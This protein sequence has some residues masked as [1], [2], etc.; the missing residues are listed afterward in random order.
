MRRAI[1]RTPRLA[2]DIS[3]IFQT[4]GPAAGFIYLRQVVKRSREIL[5]VGMLRPADEAMSGRTWRFYVLGTTIELDGRLFSGAREMYC[6]KVYFARQGFEVH[7]NDTVVDLG[8]NY[9]LFSV[10]AARCGARVIAV[11]AQ[12]GCAPEIE[13]LA[14]LNG[15]Q[16]RIQVESVMVGSGGLYGD[17]DEFL[18]SGHSQ[19]RLPQCVRFEDLLR[20]HKIER[21]DFLKIDIEG[22]EYSLLM[23]DSDWLDRVQKIAMEVH[24]EFGE[25]ETLVKYLRSREFVVEARTNE[26]HVVPMLTRESGYIFAWRPE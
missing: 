10:L 11:E 2:T 3:A 15:C 6:R 24:H 26:Q 18:G 5:A 20:A 16:D 21:I 14:K 13:Q 7:P 4:L 22:S 23:E 17:I 9:G 25:P 1:A 8:A 19:G 12:A